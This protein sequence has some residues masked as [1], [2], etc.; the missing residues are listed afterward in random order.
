MSFIIDLLRQALI[1]GEFIFNI[2]TT[3]TDQ[4]DTGN[5]FTGTETG[6]G[7]VSDATATLFLPAAYAFIIWALIFL[8][9]AAFAVYQVL[10]SQRHNPVLRRVGWWWFANL[11][12]GGL[13]TEAFTSRAF[14]LAWFLILAQLVTLV[15]AFIELRDD[16][17]KGRDFWL[18]RLPISVNLG[19]IAVAS[20]S[21]TSQFLKYGIGWTG[22]PLSEAVWT[23]LMIIV[24][25]ALSA[26]MVLKARSIVFGLV[27]IW[28]LTAIAVNYPDI[29]LVLGSA[30]IGAAAVALITVI[31]WLR[32]KRTNRQPPMLATS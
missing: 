4:A 32:S 20:I 2:V 16:A 28:A 3:G 11:L 18:V 15:A 29:R 31:G 27:V 22:D 24:T 6:I 19:W 25:V 21:N 10:P 14:T 9:R 13:W 8:L 5:A 7:A 1:F 23:A 12:A 17:R 26:F 30:S